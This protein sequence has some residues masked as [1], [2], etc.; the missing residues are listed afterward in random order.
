[1]ITIEQIN[2]GIELEFC[3]SDISTLS[4]NQLSKRFHENGLSDRINL[5]TD[6]HLRRNPNGKKWLLTVDGD[7]WQQ[8]F[9][10]ST[11][12]LNVEKFDLLVNFIKV[13]KKSKAYVR[14]N[15]GMHVHISAPEDFNLKI[16]DFTN[17]IN[18]R[19]HG[20]IWNERWEY[21]CKEQG[22]NRYT[23]VNHLKGNHV[24]V[25]LFNGTINHLTVLRRLNET[26]KLYMQNLEPVAAKKAA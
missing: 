5:Q 8:Q 9:E 3:V 4:I 22:T 7:G 25:R 11:P 2:V 18:A 23:P 20:F 24:E 15:S 17:K 1:M 26:I 6:Y 13:I 19:Y 12:I 21:L 16:S 10:V 14:K